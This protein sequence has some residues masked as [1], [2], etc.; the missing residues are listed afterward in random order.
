[1]GR[2]SSPRASE[3]AGRAYMRPAA[4]GQR[5]HDGGGTRTAGR[6]DRRQRPRDGGQH[7][8]EQDGM[9]RRAPAS[10][11]RIASWS[12]SPPRWAAAKPSEGPGR[13][14]HATVA[15]ATSADSR[16]PVEDG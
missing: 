7:Q 1:M 14:R 12:T 15:T 8:R 2:R 4:G 10:A 6:L 11:A 13:Q 9:Q 3:R 5:Q 16:D